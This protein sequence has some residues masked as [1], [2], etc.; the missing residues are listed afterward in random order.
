MKTTVRL[1]DRLLREVKRYAAERGRTLTSVLEDALRQ[2][3]SGT[4][5]RKPGGPFRMITFKGG[6]RPGVNLDDSAAL[7]DLTEKRP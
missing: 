1:D 7:W 3:L 2:F 5:R 4:A 6:L